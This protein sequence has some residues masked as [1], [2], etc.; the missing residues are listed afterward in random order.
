MNTT[1]A[2]TET[3]SFSSYTKTTPPP[4]RGLSIC[5]KRYTNTFSFSTPKKDTDSK[6]QEKQKT[7]NCGWFFVFILHCREDVKRKAALLH[8]PPVPHSSHQ[9]SPPTP[10][11]PMNDHFLIQ[12]PPMMI[13][14]NELKPVSSKNRLKLNGHSCNAVHSLFSFF[15][16]LSLSPFFVSF[17]NLRS[18]FRKQTIL[19]VRYVQSNVQTCDISLWGTDSRLVHSWNRMRRFSPHGECRAGEARGVS[20]F[21][22]TSYVGGDVGRIDTC[23]C[24]CNRNT[25]TLHQACFLSRVSGEAE[26]RTSFLS[27]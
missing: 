8:A 2:T 22:R 26:T 21:P 4:T 19:H 7:T 15:F 9:R 3:A 5:E 23:C 16:S 18:I 10:S 13:N 12:S 27:V 11:P 1:S 14:H 20:F 17:C 25:R 6:R 24:C